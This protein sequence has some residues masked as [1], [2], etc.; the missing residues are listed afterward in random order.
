MNQ[1]PSLTELTAFIQVVRHASFRA[2]ADE[3]GV[4]PSTLSHMMRALEERL[5][6]RLFNRTT[7]S[8]AP[9]E[10]GTRL[11]QSLTPVLSELDLALH[12]VNRFRE[13]PSGVLRINASEAAA[14]LLVNR[15]VPVFLDRYPEMHV[16]VVTEGRLIDVVAEGFDAGVRLAESVPQD[17]VAVP[18]GGAVT[19]LAVASPAYLAAHGTPRTPDDLARHRCIRFRLPG[20]KLYR[21]EFEQHGQPLRVEVSGPLTLDHIRLMAEAAVKGVG[22]AY[23]TAGA[24]QPAI[25]RGLLVPVLSDWVPSFE[26]HCLYYPSHRLVPAGLRAFVDVVK[27]LKTGAGRAPESSSASRTP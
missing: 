17:M 3:L 25:D 7:R 9:T 24:A 16:D 6:V 14:D 12:D 8:V 2:A 15:F 5:G 20:G 21:W 26:G 1:R 22:I 4:S 19:F 27:E 23:V 10:A 18:L 13:R 11:F